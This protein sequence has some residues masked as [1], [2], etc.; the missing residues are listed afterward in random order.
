MPLDFWTAVH[1][2]AEVKQ[3]SASLMVPHAHI[4]SETESD[5]TW[6]YLQRWKNQKNKE[7]EGEFLVD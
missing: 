7:F 6:V 2:K 1:R 4:V 3:Q 5:T